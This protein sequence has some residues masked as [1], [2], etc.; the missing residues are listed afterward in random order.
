MAKRI[1]GA[2]GVVGAVAAATLG[3]AVGCGD[4]F[5]SS[6][7]RENHT[8]AAAAG[9]SGVSGASDGA[10]GSEATTLGGSAAIAGASD[11][12]AGAGGA[13]GCRVDL[14]CSNDNAEDGA[15]TCDDGTCLPGNPPPAI[16]SFTPKS[17]AVEV[18]P[19]TSVVIEFSE[20]L[21]PETVTPANIRVQDGTTVLPGAL[22]YADGKVTFTPDSPLTLLAPYTLSVTTGV[23]D[24]EGAPLLT[25]LSSTFQVRDGAWKTIDVV[26]GEITGMSDALPMTST[27][28]TLVAWNGSGFDR[29]PAT[30]KWFLRGEA[31][32][33]MV[34]SFP[35]NGQPECEQ[36]SSSANAAGI[37][38]VVWVSPNSGQG[39]T[40]QQYRAGGWLSSAT[41][42]VKNPSAQR[43]RLAVAPSGA[44]T[45][46]EHDTTT[47]SFVWTTD[48]EGNWPA[49][50]QLPGT[51]A[52]LSKHLA[53]SQ[54]S[55]V[56]DS[57]GKGW[58]VWKAQA[59]DEKELE[60]IVASRLA[61]ANGKWAAATDLPGS[62]AA[63]PPDASSGAPRRGAPVVALDS[64]GEPLVLW[65]DGDAQGK[66]M[67]S[68]FVQSA[69]TAPESISG[70]LVVDAFYEP[71]AL[72]FDGQA[73][74]AA[75]T[76]QE[77]GEY[78]AYTARYDLK[79]GWDAYQKQQTVAADGSIA[80]KMP[81]LVS[82]GRGNL[83]LVYAKGEGS[84]FELLYQRY[85]NE[86]WGSI[87]PVPG[88][89][90]SSPDFEAKTL[91]LS[92]SSNGLAA[93]AWADYGSPNDFIS[94]VRLASFY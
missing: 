56:F 3:A 92:M 15:E 94:S 76:A 32:V 12:L 67:A 26:K 81:R 80:A 71:P 89:A 93:L 11:G 23:A 63:A 64:Q 90:V 28:R 33:D 27:G 65:V 6:D 50:G 84:S 72:A 69:W 77:A 13:S 35:T 62:V 55:A 49:T 40:V 30:A 88:G 78:Y 29:C 54:T 25:E 36:L 75:W 61:T 37:A 66:L 53:R 38:G 47:G 86:T 70:A 7:C 31:D 82:D 79:T 52:P 19:D 91:A 85:A 5:A 59:S 39:V 51:G 73:F 34:R 83:L 58:A 68:R 60:R 9:E 21:D 43:P 44:M 42:L 87:N 46:F 57:Q 17:D 14:D 10:G 8:C 74:V 2:G 20:P 48:V 24:A 45:V 16:V 4:G 41:L 1:L 22:A 18:E